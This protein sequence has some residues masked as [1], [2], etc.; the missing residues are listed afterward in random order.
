MNKQIFLA[1]VLALCP[2]SVASAQSV[3]LSAPSWAAPLVASDTMPTTGG[4]A[5]IAADGVALAARVT[6]APL[7]GGVARVIRYESSEEASVLTLRRFTGD[8]GTGWWLWGA[9]TPLVIHPAPAQ[10]AELETLIRAALNQSAS[11]QP[12]GPVATSERCTGEEAFLEVSLEGRARSFTLGC[13]GNADAAG[14]LSRKLSEI[15]GSRN[16]EELAAAAA[17]EVLDADRA[18]AAMAASDGVPAAFA[19]YAAPDAIMIRGEGDNVVGHD[20]IV[21]RFANWPDGATLAWTPRFA[22]V[23]TRGD[24]A[25]SWGDSVYTAPDGT[26]SAGRYVSVWTRDLGGEWRYAA[27]VGAD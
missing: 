19:H 17:Q 21:A 11:A 15:A 10:K 23:S 8:V 27:D 9:D 13:V 7:Q 2:F 18:F 16:H 12:G 22:R 3:A 4:R 6:I 1:G 25:W 5:D 14:R 26:S 20:A 24:M